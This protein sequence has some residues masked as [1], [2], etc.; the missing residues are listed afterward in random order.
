MS[1]AKQALIDARDLIA[2][3]ERWTKHTFARDAKGK[4][5]D[6]KSPDATCFCGL[7]ALI[8]VVN[9]DLAAFKWARVA[10][11]DADIEHTVSM[12]NDFQGH[13]AVLSLFDKAI[14]VSV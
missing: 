12:V 8:K 11:A 10:L 1:A 7:G 6:P 14:E 2:D 3:P 4:E 5:V 13:D 9:G